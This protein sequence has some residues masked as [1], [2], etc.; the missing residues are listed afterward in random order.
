[1]DTCPG[2]LSVTMFKD[3]YNK[4]GLDVEV[5]SVVTAIKE[6]RWKDEIL[7]LRRDNKNANDKKL[8]LPCVTFSGTFSGGKSEENMN[9]Y[10]GLVIVDIDE[11]DQKKLKRARKKLR[12]DGYVYAFFFS[13][14]K[15]LKILFSTDGKAIEHKNVTFKNVKD[16]VETNYSL[17]VDNS[18]QNLN[19]L[20]FVSY[21]KDAHINEHCDI[22]EVD[23]DLYGIREKPKRRVDIEDLE[24]SNDKDY[25][26]KKAFEWASTTHPYVEGDRN[27][28]IHHLGCILNEAG[29]SV[30]EAI[31][32]I[33][34]YLPTPD[35]KWIKDVKNL[36]RRNSNKFATRPIRKMP[37]EIAT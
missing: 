10:I 29:V 37:G 9:D 14:R 27:N 1:M 22:F 4:Y 5:G 20:C 19:R 33:D 17:K 30:E 8:K 26:F 35:E 11:K 6:G 12:E 25:I 3:A 24:V 28:H 15:G 2:T 34:I 21:D 18:G 36:Y 32:L 16:Y 7:S 23:R 13:P 31:G